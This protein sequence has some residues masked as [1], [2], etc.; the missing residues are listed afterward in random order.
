MKDSWQRPTAWLRRP[1]DPS[2]PM[3]ARRFAIRLLILLPFAAV[4]LSHGWGFAHMFVM[5]TGF[6]ALYA[7]FTAL[8]QREKFTAHTLNHYDEALGMAALCLI[9]RLFI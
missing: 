5:L 8:I 7:F 4:A 1:V 9:A 6:N 3:V 2:V